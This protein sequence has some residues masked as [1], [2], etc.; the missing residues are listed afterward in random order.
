MSDILDMPAESERRFV[1]AGFWIRVAAAIIDALVLW[2]IEWIVSLFFMGDTG[3]WMGLYASPFLINLLY[4]AAMESSSR[5]A[6]LGKLAVGIKVGDANGD[7]ITF[8]HALG[9][10]LAKLISA[11]ILFIGYMMAGWDAKCQALHDKI[12]NTYVYYSK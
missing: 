11:F 8:T 7:Q 12:A 4:Y 5:Q 9:R 10:N 1:Y 2:L 6:T 3:D